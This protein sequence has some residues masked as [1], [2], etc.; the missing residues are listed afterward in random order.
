MKKNYKKFYHFCSGVPL[1]WWNISSS[2]AKN[3][4]MLAV[5][6]LLS[7]YLLHRMYSFT[8][9]Y[10]FEFLTSISIKI[11]FIFFSTF[12]FVWVTLVQTSYKHSML[13]LLVYTNDFGAAIRKAFTNYFEYLDIS[14]L[15]QSDTIC[16]YQY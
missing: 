6:S 5:L 10:N 12:L 11:W 13:S 16:H 8:K 7:K 2:E 14:V 1:H 3:T 9:V 4:P 15:I